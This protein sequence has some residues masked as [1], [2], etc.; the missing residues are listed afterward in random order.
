MRQSRAIEQIYGRDGW[1]VERPC[2]SFALLFQRQRDSSLWRQ[3]WLR[4]A[5]SM[6]RITKCHFPI[7]AKSAAQITSQAT[8]AQGARPRT[9]MIDRAI[10]DRSHTHF[11]NGA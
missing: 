3:I 5:A 8:Q 11:A 4:E 9:I 10:F 7:L 1:L 6:A 2:D